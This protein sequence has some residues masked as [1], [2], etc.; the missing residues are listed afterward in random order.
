M[1]RAFRTLL[2]A[3]PKAFREEYGS[4]MAQLFAD[5]RRI[6]GEGALRAWSRETL[7]AVRTGPR[8]RL[9]HSMTRNLVLIVSAVAIF[10]SVVL[11]TMVG[12]LVAVGLGALWFLVWRDRPVGTWRAS[13]WWRWYAAA[14][15]STVL[16]F[17]VLAVD[18]DDDGELTTVGWTVAYL[19]GNAAICLA[20]IGTVL[21]AVQLVRRLRTP[22]LPA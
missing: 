19:S 17:A 4:D 6:D 8:L 22:P 13:G 5:R 11:G 10:A 12:L 21:G 1:S 3:Y 15:A 18:A 20:A 2:L 9:E 14:A 7:D 16:L